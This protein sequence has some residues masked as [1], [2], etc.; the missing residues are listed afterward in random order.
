[1][2][3]RGLIEQT[4]IGATIFIARAVRTGVASHSGRICGDA[5]LVMTPLQAGQ[6]FGIDDLMCGAIMDELVTSGFLYKKAEG[7]Y[8][9]STLIR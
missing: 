5:G 1:M 4:I 9:I 6:L 3:A 2:E 8:A 7:G